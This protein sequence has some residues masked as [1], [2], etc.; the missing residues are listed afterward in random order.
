LRG[1]TDEYVNNMT[2]TYGLWELPNIKKKR[3][4]EKMEID[5][6]VRI[7]KKYIIAIDK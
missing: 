4:N 7:E 1:A 5:K 6:K 2:F 3:L